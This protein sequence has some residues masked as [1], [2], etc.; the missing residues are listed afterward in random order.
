MSKSIGELTMEDRGE[1]KYRIRTYAISERG[2]EVAEVW[3]GRNYALLFTAAP[4]LLAALRKMAVIETR[5]GCHCVICKAKWRS[6]EKERHAKGCAIREA[7]G[8]KS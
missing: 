1:S 4:K 5:A 2:Y 7:K 8:E 3:A 6:D